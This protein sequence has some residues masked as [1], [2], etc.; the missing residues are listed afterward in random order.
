[1]TS[2]KADQR[3]V[4]CRRIDRLLCRQARRRILP[5]S[6]HHARR[7]L[8]CKL[9]H[10]SCRFHPP[11]TS[12]EELYLHL[13]LSQ[14]QAPPSFYLSDQDSFSVQNWFGS[15]LAGRVIQYGQLQ[16]FETGKLR[17][18]MRQVLVPVIIINGRHVN[19]DFESG[20]QAQLLGSAVPDEWGRRVP[21]HLEGVAC[22]EK[23]LGL[24][25]DVLADLEKGQTDGLVFCTPLLPEG[26]AA[27][28]Y[29]DGPDLY[30]ALS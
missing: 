20:Y 5:P 28:E 14:R 18:S 21:A 13:T 29:V 16:R 24:L 11:I 9:F 1:M 12:S 17:D 4:L 15:A 22:V 30:G 3:I 2:N 27:S 6:P 8:F 10:F 19:I 26:A 23:K 7:Q 25:V